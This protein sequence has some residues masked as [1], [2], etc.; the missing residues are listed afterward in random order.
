MLL[1]QKYFPEPDLAPT[2]LLLSAKDPAPGF[3]L[4]MHF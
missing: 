4:D 2:L 1:I 3:F